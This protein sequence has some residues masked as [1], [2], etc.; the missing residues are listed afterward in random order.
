MQKLNIY[1]IVIAILGFS[2]GLCFGM[3]MLSVLGQTDCCTP[4]P[5]PASVPRFPQ[6]AT[7]TVYIDTSSGF[8]PTEVQ[9]IRAGW[10]SWNGQPNSS[11]IRYNVVE[12]STPPSAGGAN[13]ILVWYEDRYNP[14]VG[15]AGLRAYQ[16]GSAVYM[17]VIYYQ[18]IR[19]GVP[20]YL[21]AFI[22]TTSRHEAGH[23]LGL[24]HAE[25][26][27]PGTT[28]IMGPWDPIE[29]FITQCD[30]DAVS[31]QPAYPSPT[32]NSNADAN[33]GTTDGIES[34]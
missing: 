17:D 11:G 22:R 29:T 6:G 34:G 8:I 12:T 5:R 19:E 25:N 23:G 1:S 21:P 32:G 10:E 18:N 16:I 14:E 30:N 27:P 13:T 3:G 31:S 4:P 24:D 26:C 15:G 33:T 28:S 20:E 2:V 9:A 7:V